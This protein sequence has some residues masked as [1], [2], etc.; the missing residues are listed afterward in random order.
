M[1]YSNGVSKRP[2]VAHFADA[3]GHA[4]IAHLHIRTSYA[5]LHCF[6]YTV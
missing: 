6:L 1:G 5:L 2:R 3:V 4:G